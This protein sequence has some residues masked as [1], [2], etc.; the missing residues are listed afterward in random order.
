M[1]FTPNLKMLIYWKYELMKDK[2]LGLESDT[3]ETINPA[4]V[5]V[6]S[7]LESVLLRF[8]EV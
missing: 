6:N 4:A 8:C 5:T 7:V 1:D 3:N 2:I